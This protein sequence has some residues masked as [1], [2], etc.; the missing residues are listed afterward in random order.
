MSASSK[1]QYIY[2]IVHAAECVSS[3]WFWVRFSQ[4]SSIN[5]FK[6]KSKNSNY[7]HNLFWILFYHSQKI[8]TILC[9]RFNWQNSS[10]ETLVL[11]M[12][13]MKFWIVNFWI[14]F[15][16]T[17]PVCI[18][19]RQF[20]LHPLEKSRLMTSYIAVMREFRTYIAG[21]VLFK[22]CRRMPLPLKLK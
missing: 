18:C 17:G 4:V 6:K 3:S 12:I 20:T 21:V 9:T 5:Y 13:I 8:E 15:Y 14:E 1:P 10:F 2:C 19:C 22:V 16:K 11:I 7:F